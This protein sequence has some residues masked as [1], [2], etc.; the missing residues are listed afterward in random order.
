MIDKLRGW[1]RLIFCAV[2]I[3]IATVAIFT[4]KFAP[5]DWVETIKWLGSFYLGSDGVE[6]VAGAWKGRPP[7][8]I[9]ATPPSA[10]R[11]QPTFAAGEDR[12]AD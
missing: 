11:A 10:P 2:V 4:G 3:A 8:V 7:A 6:K 5:A 1:R 9:Q 12:A